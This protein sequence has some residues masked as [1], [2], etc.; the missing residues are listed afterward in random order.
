MNDS[1]DYMTNMEECSETENAA[2]S[3]VHYN[4]PSCSSGRN[5]APQALN[6]QA[7]RSQATSHPVTLNAQ[8]LLYLLFRIHYLGRDF[9]TNFCAL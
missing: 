2:K 8:Y 7:F 9:N 4:I 6:M 5:T 1:Y 3:G